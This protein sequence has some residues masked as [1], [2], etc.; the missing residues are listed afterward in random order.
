MPLALKN[1]FIKTIFI[2]TSLFLASCGGGGGGDSSSNTGGN[3]GGTGSTANVAPT[4]SLSASENVD[5]GESFS[6]TASASD[7]DGSISSYQWTQ[8]SGQSVTISN[9][10]SNTLS[11][12]APSVTSNTVLTFELTVTDND[13]ATATASIQVTVMDAIGGTLPPVSNTTLSGNIVNLG[14]GDAV[15]GA[16]VSI[17]NK[18]VT[19]DA[20]G[21]YTITNLPYDT[22]TIVS[23]EHAGFAT[24]IKTTSNL[25][26]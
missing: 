10:T 6:I 24:Q 9:A 26:Y 22:R 3:S 23:V 17:G 21:N 5:S 13:N 1:K 18:S 8:T 25:I 15:S 12:T 4:I 19:T 2:I 7:S 11:F 14:N 20:N 16:T